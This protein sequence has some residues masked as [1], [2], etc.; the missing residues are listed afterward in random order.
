MPMILGLVKF[1][2]QADAWPPESRKV[3]LRT[4]LVGGTNGGGQD[5]QL[6][7]C[8]CLLPNLRPSSRPATHFCRWYIPILNLSV[9]EPSP[10][11]CVE[12]EL[13][14]VLIFYSHPMTTF[15]VSASLGQ[16]ASHGPVG[17]GLPVPTQDQHCSHQTHEAHGILALHLQ[18]CSKTTS[19]GNVQ[20]FT[21]PSMPLSYSTADLS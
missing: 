8:Y 14:I 11:H 18:M 2:P 3:H 21:M 5:P 1:T 15:P 12:T 4:L 10:L 9:R 16:D 13:N 20:W 19:V 7:Q 6:W 17:P